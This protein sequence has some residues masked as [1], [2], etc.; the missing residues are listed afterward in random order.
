MNKNLVTL[1]LLLVSTQTS[2]SSE[3]SD[4]KQQQL[5]G[6]EQTKNEFKAYRRE[7]NDAFAEYRHKVERIWGKDTVTP[8]NIHWVSYIDNLGQRSVVNFED[9]IIDVEVAL[10]AQDDDNI[11]KKRLE[12]TILKALE[13]G[14]DKRPIQQLAKQPVSMPAGDAVLDDQV[15]KPDGSVADTSDYQSLASD[16]ASGA[17][18]KNLRGNDGNTRIVYRAQ[19]KLVP[20][21]IRIRARKYQHLV[22]RYAAKYEI[23]GPLVFAVIETESYFNP[24]ARSAAPAF[25]LM[26]LVPT[27]GARDA[28]RY[29]YNRDRIVSDTYL[30]DPENNIRL[31]SAYLKRLNSDYLS[32]I[33][34]DQS[35]MLAT[36]AAY[37]TGAGNVM[38]A[39]AGRYSRARHGS[40][41][42]YRRK[43]FAVINRMTPQQVYDYMREN[44]SHQEAR[45]YIEKVTGRISKYQAS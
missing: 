34:S 23:P 7:L 37:N 44:L 35:R 43:A 13:Q 15:S 19:L 40:Y 36:I 22:D 20:D 8:D 45:R 27:S 30:Y 39:F 28:Y 18:K 32:G 29:I 42:N 21:H 16:A 1:S 9:G 24:T 31:G 25:G 33:N 38:N 14:A 11:G 26:Q 3:F 41:S 17:E 2:Y 12:E 6:F 10:P 4:W 5:T